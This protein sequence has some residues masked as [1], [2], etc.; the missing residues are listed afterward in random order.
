MSKSQRNALAS[1]LRFLGYTVTTG[2]KYLQF[3]GITC[4]WLTES[5]VWHVISPINNRFYCTIQPG[6]PAA[7]LQKI[8]RFYSPFIHPAALRRVFTHLPPPAANAA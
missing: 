2:K 5:E 1:H 8:V 7:V 3:S 6:S 4:M